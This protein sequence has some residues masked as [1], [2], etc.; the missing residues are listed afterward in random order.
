MVLVFTKLLL[1]H[2]L[3]DFVIQ[4]NKWVDDKKEHGLKS[5][6]FWLHI[7]LSAVLTYI[8]LMDWTNWIIPV[9]ILIT[10]GTIDYWKITRERYLDSR[11][12][13]KNNNNKKG[14][15]ANKYF[16]IDQL[17]HLTMIIIA[18][19]YITNNFSYL[20]PFIKNFLTD[21]KSILIITAFIIII[22]PVG[23]IVG[24]ITQPFRREIDTYDSLSN[25]GNYI[26]ITERI[27]VLVFI[28][29]GHYSV[30]GFLIAGKSILRIGRDNDEEARKKTEYV[31]I[32]TLMSFMSST[33]IGLLT[34]YLI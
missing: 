21:E 5:K 18:W 20:F 25:A 34:I 9:F 17:L 7:I 8:I 15:E 4:S 11:N 1:A 10:H 32:G 27:L 22:W 14:S 3:T 30:I 26:G 29:L 2:V 12:N 28:L 19:L 31:L 24:K 13:R 33:L 16:F 6:F 23:I